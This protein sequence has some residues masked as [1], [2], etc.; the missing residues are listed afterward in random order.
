MR[1]FSTLPAG[2][3]PGQR[4]IAGTR[5]P[6]SMTVPLLCANGVCPPSGQVKT[7]V[8]LS[9]VKTT[10]VLSST[11][12][13]FSFF[14]TMPMSSS[15]CAMPAS[16]MDQPFFELRSA[17]YFGDRC[18]TMCMRVGLSQRKNGLPSALALSR[19][20][21][22]PCRGS[23]RRRFPCASGTARRRPRS[24]ACRPC[25]S[26]D[27]P[28]RRRRWS[29]TSGPC[30]AD[31]PAAAG[32]ADSSGGTDPPSHRGDR[33]SRRTRRSRAPW[34]GTRSGRPGGSCRTGRWRSPSTSTPSRW[35]RPRAGMPI[36]EPAWP[37]V[38]M[39]VRIGSSPVMKLARPAVQ[40]ASA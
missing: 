26:A 21:P 18:V 36:G 22:A 2:T 23:R 24:S 40:L 19:N 28:S 33:G 8:P 7:S 17:W 9:V 39:P 31:R 14:I 35:S 6:P 29:P 30:C 15:I 25:P 11:P 16:W 5:K 32:P 3:L 38:V 20:L 34:A 37:T 12:M 4:I 1:P 13:S 27:P 10:I